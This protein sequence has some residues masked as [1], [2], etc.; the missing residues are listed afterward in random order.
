MIDATQMGLL[1]LRLEGTK[2]TPE[3][4]VAVVESSFC[5]IGVT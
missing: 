2:K 1:W 5:E 4:M 3:E